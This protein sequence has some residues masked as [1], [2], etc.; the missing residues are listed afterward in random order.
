M[1]F[2]PLV[3]SCLF[4]LMCGVLSVE[5]AERVADSCLGAYGKQ[6]YATAAQVCRKEAEQGSEASAFTLAVLYA[7]GLGVKKDYAQAI[8]WLKSAA[9]AGH[10]GAAYNLGVAYTRG[11][12]VE[13]NLSKAV[14]WFKQA[15]AL[16]N[17]YA[18]RDLASLY[19]EGLGIEKDPAQAYLLYK[20]SAEQG[21]TVSQL[22]TGLMLLRGE[23]VAR[24]PDEAKVWLSKA[25]QSND[26]T[27]QYTMGLLLSDAD[28]QASAD[29]YRKASTQGNGYA[30]HNLALF[31]LYGRGVKQDYSKALNWAEKS[32]AAGVSESKGLQQQIL[33]LMGENRP[34]PHQYVVV[35]DA[36]WL[37][38]KPD[39]DYLIQISRQ[40]SEKAAYAYLEKHKVTGP[41][42]IYREALADKTT[43]IVTY[44]DYRDLSSAKDA[45]K[46]LP[47][48]VQHYKPWVRSY[49]SLKQVLAE[50]P[51]AQKLKPEVV[52]D[53]SVRFAAKK[54]VMAAT[55]AIES[56]GS[57]GRQ[58]A[59]WLLSKP[60]NAIAIQLMAV[61]SSREPEIKSYL[62]H[63]G[64]VDSAVYYETQRDAGP[65]MV[66]V[67]NREFSS[68]SEAK[69]AVK[70]LPA[71]VQRLRPWVRTFGSLQSKYRQLGQ[72]T[73]Q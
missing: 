22:Q 19:V 44:G 26:P 38:A 24:N 52:A 40:D 12:G 70:Q 51:P 54:P 60:K 33:Q 32:I 34:E 30:M 37:E 48:G 16:G 45:V 67:L 10:S 11:D 18:Q 5:A 63:H 39:E 21:I 14:H 3:R 73:A 1:T 9:E 68:G 64:L 4:T 6:A 8:T 47:E 66:V 69:D 42:G 36:R 28:P 56:T 65:Y 50:S 29:W 20:A 71:A 2:R 7:K 53:T 49:Q 59:S 23:G 15:V 41:I 31:Y 72:G 27:A 61:P 62:K 35:R 13:V 58:P 43:Y 57:T 25:A 46:S 55:V 17:P